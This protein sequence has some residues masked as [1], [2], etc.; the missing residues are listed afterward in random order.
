MV[1]RVPVGVGPSGV[2][3][4]PDGRLVYVATTDPQA[5]SVV[6]VAT[7]TVTGAVP[8]DEP[9][10]GMALSP[11][12][13]RLYGANPQGATLTVLDPATRTVT[14]TIEVASRP[15]HV[16]VSP[17]GRTAY[18]SGG[19]TDGS[20]TRS[21]QL[22]PCRPTAYPTDAQ[23]LDFRTVSR[24]GPE[25][26]EVR[27]LAAYPATDVAAEAVAGFRRVLAACRTGGAAGEGT[28]WRWVVDERV[29]VGDEGFLAASTTGGPTFAPWGERLAVTRVGSMVF[30]AY[31]QGEY[32]TAD[33]DDGARSTQAVAE[34]FVT[35][36]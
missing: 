19:E 16:V 2:T 7:H 21:W 24:R 34:R 25:L 12:G 26:F 30:L 18:V 10:L 3:F 35:G 15:R 22:D 4:S 6:D 1:A 33:V 8:T 29:N 32:T 23:R 13:T 27:Q 9:I 36:R 11:D 20:V 31:D 5:V 14:G 17:D 28:R